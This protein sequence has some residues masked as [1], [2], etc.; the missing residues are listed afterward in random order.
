MNLKY[1]D[2]SQIL[3]YNRPLT[4]YTTELKNTK[5]VKIYTIKQKLICVLYE[6]TIKK[7]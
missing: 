1:V 7:H 5:F 2:I 4:I 3:T 6:I